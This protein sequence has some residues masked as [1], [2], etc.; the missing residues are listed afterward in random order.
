V[1][2]GAAAT[3]KGSTASWAQDPRVWIAAAAAIALALAV[4]LGVSTYRAGSLPGQT[5]G[6]ANRAA[7]QVVSG[8][9]NGAATVAGLFNLRSPGERVAGALASL[10]H[11]RQ[12]ALH[13]RALAKVRHPAAPLGPLA[14]IVGASPVPPAVPPPPAPLYNVVGKPPVAVAAAP[15]VGGGPVIFPT[16]AP[17]GGGGGGIVVPPPLTITPPAPPGAPVTPSVPEPATWTMMLVGFAMIA[18]SLRRHRAA[19]LQSATG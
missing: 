14:S 5:G 17:P 1:P 11:K 8:I 4:A 6:I 19:D 7:H 13:E 3:P 2:V 9:A 12:P 15:P 18:R 10:K 16:A